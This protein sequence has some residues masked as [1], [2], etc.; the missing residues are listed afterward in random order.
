MT[1]K[2]VLLVLATVAMG[3]VVAAPSTQKLAIGMHEMGF[4]MSGKTLNSGIPAEITI[5]NDGKAAH[6]LQV[7][8]TPKSTPSDW[9]SYIDANKLWN[10]S[11]ATLTIN[12]KVKKGSFMEVELEPG[13]KAVLKFVPRVKGSFEVGCHKT[14]HYEAGMKDALRVN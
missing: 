5:T 12:G 10:K 9:D 7:Y 3:L 6:E 11:T 1:I 13:Q 2:K 14:G 4:T 8:L